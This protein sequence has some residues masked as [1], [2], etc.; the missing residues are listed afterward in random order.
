M[1]SK[2]P[3]AKHPIFPLKKRLRKRK[4]GWRWKDGRAEIVWKKGERNIPNFSALVFQDEGKTNYCKKL[5]ENEQ[6]NKNT[7]IVPLFL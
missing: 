6:T 2:R 4:W 3:K 1:L 7:F 5:R